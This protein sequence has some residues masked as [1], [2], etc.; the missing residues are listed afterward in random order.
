MA[1]W[2]GFMLPDPGGTGPTLGQG[3]KLLQV[4]QCSQELKQKKWF[5]EG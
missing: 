5:G 4:T 3:T 2:L 1:Q